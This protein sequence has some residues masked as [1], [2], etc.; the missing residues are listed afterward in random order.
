MRICPVIPSHTGNCPESS[1]KT[2]VRPFSTL[3]INLWRAPRWSSNRVADVPSGERVDLMFW[4]VGVGFW[5]IY[6]A[7]SEASKKWTRP[8]HHWKQALNH[9]AIMYEDRLPQST[10]K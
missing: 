7:I 10:S 9:F 1:V 3:A 2:M 4:I 5:L 6:M 8:I